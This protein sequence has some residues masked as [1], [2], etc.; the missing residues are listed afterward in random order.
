MAAESAYRAY[1]A[2]RVLEVLSSGPR[3]SQEIADRC[4]LH[5]NTVL[6]ALKELCLSGRI[7]RAPKDRAGAGKL[8][9][10]YALVADAVA[11]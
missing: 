1:R 11:A 7:T 9:L 8:P 5:K 3:T 10:V 2:R 4:G 6:R